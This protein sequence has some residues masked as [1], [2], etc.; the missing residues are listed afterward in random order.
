MLVIE[1]VVLVVLL[2]AW[3]LSARARHTMSVS[4][5]FVIKSRNLVRMLDAYILGCSLNLLI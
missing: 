1:V 3:A 2:V 5:L 4:V